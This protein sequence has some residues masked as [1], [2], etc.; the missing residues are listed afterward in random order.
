MYNEYI[1]SV[2]YI[3]NDFFKR[4][5]LYKAHK[6]VPYC[7]SCGTPLSSHEVAQGYKEVEDP[8]IYI[9]F[10]AREEE[11]T[12]YLAWTT[13][14][15]TLISNVALAVHPDF[16]Y[17]K[18]FHKGEYYILAKER[19]D[20]LDSEYEIISEFSG[21]ELEYKQYEP[22]FNFVPVDK[23]AWYIGL[24]D[25]VSMEEGTGIVHTAPAFGQD[26]YQL[27]KK[28]NLPLVQPVDAEGKFTSPVEPW[29]GIFVKAADKDI[30]RFLKEKGN[31]YKREQVKHSYPHCWRCQSPLIYYARDT[32]YI[33]T[34]DFKEQ[35]LENNRQIRWYPPFVGEKRFGE[36][37]E[38]NVDWALSRDRFWGTPLNIWICND[39][40]A[41]TSIGSIQEL[42][43]K[44]T[45]KNGLPIPENLELHRPYIDEVVLKCEHCGGTMIRTPEVIDCWF[46][47]GSMPFA[48]WHYPFENADNFDKELFPADFISEGIDQTRGW[49]YS[50]LAI[51]TLFKGVSSYKSCL[52]NEM[53]LDKNGQK[54]SKSKG[55]AVDP[56]ELMQEYGADAIRWYLLEVS[57]PWVPTRFDVDGVREI[58]GKF[59]GTLKNTYSFFA[60]YANID[61]Y[62][63]SIYSH[64]W[65]RIA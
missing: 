19:L 35:L 58:V 10:K 49:F 63:A 41:R 17:V 29:A 32:W 56:I 22:L 60:T 62:D 26:D 14:P 18:V 42:R 40:G 65:Q 61:G 8:S 53:I 64:D 28:Y 45:L 20:V 51:S 59:I 54:M 12:L 24:A 9:K 34:S 55:N 57:P 33:R 1:E 7:P 25:Y 47:S 3:L 16:T 43:D 5:L 38:N 27:G 46:D 2:W 37:L 15:W 21:R 13:T 50:L 30:I 23:P 52:V 6:I 39:C 4:G 36:W 48:Q 44:G 11:N 31:L